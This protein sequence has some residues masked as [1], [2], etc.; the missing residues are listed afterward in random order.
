MSLCWKNRTLAHVLNPRYANLDLEITVCVA[1]SAYRGEVKE[2]VLEALL[3]KSGVLAHPGFFSPDNFTFGTSLDRSALEATIQDVPGVRAVEEM[4]IRRRGWFDWRDFTELS[5]KVG[6]NEIIRLENNPLHPE[7]G[8][9][10][11][12]MVG[13]A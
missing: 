9:L 13:G 1:P 2:S 12:T 5:Y 8:S 10:K 4:R 3:G 11:L 7:Q 6:Q